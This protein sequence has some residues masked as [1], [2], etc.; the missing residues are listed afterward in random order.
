MDGII[1]FPVGKQA[2]YQELKINI[3]VISIYNKISDEIPYVGVDAQSA[4]R[5]AIGYIADCQY[6]R[7]MLVNSSITKKVKSGLNVYT[8]QERQKDIPEKSG[9]PAILWATPTVNAFV[10]APPE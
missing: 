5:D 3:P 1:V 7:V 8:L 10:M 2:D 4:M 9:R 6:E